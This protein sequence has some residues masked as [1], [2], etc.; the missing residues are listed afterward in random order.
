[1]IMEKTNKKKNEVI[2][3]QDGQPTRRKFRIYCAIKKCKNYIIGRWGDGYGCMTT[4]EGSFDARNQ[5]WRCDKH[6]KLEDK[7]KQKQWKE[8]Q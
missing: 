7:N 1:M 4:K 8:Q 6:S 3:N 5:E 2:F